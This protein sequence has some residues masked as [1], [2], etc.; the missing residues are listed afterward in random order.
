MNFFLQNALPRWPKRGILLPFF[1]LWLFSAPALAGL[2]QEIKLNCQNEKLEAVLK[3]IGKQSGLRILFRNADVELR[4]RV[5][6]QGTFALEK[7][8]KD[9]L[10]KH[11]LDYKIVG[12]QIVVFGRKKPAKTAT[13]PTENV[14]TQKTEVSG[15]VTDE[16]GEGLPGVNIIIKGTTTGTA[17][18]FEGRYTLVV[19]KSA[20]LQFSAVGFKAQEI[21][22][23]NQTRIDIML[24][25]NLAELEEV[26]V[27][28]YGEV[29]KS[30]LTGAVASLDTE[31]LESRP[32]TTVNSALQGAI[33]GLTIT[34]N[35]GQPGREGFSL[36][37]RDF[38]SVNGGS[39]PL[40]LIDGLPGS[41]DLLNPDD[42]Q[43]MSVLK[44]A[45][46][47]IYGSRAAG[48]VILITTKTGE[49]GKPTIE[50]KSNLTVK[51]PQGMYDQPTM[52]EYIE[53]HREAQSNAGEALW[54]PD[55]IYQKFL[56]GTGV[57]GVDEWFQD[58][59]KNNPR[60]YFYGETDWEDE[61]F[62]NSYI[63]NNSLS[64][65]GGGDKSKYRVSLGHIKDEGFFSIG[66][67]VME[68]YNL[69]LNYSYNVTDWLDVDAIVAFER[70]EID[71]T[72]ESPLQQY[73]RLNLMAPTH[74]ADGS[75][76][77]TW[78][79]FTNPLQLLDE[80]ARRYDNLTRLR[81]NFKATVKLAKGLKA[82]GQIGYNHSFDDYKIERPTFERYH[83]NGAVTAKVNN[84][85]RV[86]FSNYKGLYKNLTGFLN[87]TRTLGENHNFGLTAGYSYEE[88]SNNRVNAWRKDLI[89]NDLFAL[90]LGNSEEQF[91]SQSGSKW[92]IESYFGRF[93]YDFAG[94]YLIEANFRRDRSSKFHPDVR[95]GFFPGVSLGWAV[96]E[97]GFMQNVPVLDFLKLRASYGETGN[98]SIANAYSYIQTIDIG[99]QYPFG[100]GS[101]TARATLGGLP[102]VEGTW[103]TM[104]TRNFGVDFA[105]LDSRL[106]GSFDYYRK[107]NENMLINVVFPQ[108]LGASA[109]KVNEGTLEVKGWE[110]SLSWRDKIGGFQYFVTG[111]LS[112]SQN[113]LT[114]LGGKDT[115][116]AGLVGTREGYPINSYFGYD[117]MGPIKTEEELAEFKAMSGV[118]QNIQLGD[119]RYRD[120]D[121]NGRIDPY[122]DEDE[123]GDL[124]YLGNTSPRYNYS[125]N[126]GGSFRN[127]DIA[128]FF[129]GVGKKTTYLGGQFGAP[130]QGGAKWYKPNAMYH[131]TT[132]QPAEMD[133]NGNV[134]KEAREGEYPRLST[135][136]GIVGWNWR[137]SR[138]RALD[139]AY[140][141][142]KNVTVGYT[143][144]KHLT[145]RLR[146][147]R[148]RVFANGT[149]LLTFHNMK[150]GY[151]PEQPPGSALSYPFAKTYT[152]G[153]EVRF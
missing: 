153:L 51:T 85:N 49:K 28:G 139:G 92:G 103:E 90:P 91:N 102:S 7:T 38:S 68:R 142:L 96:S 61:L 100:S 5:S 138:L 115:Y 128:L 88:S 81:T 112:D 121:G 133:G 134:V 36:Q 24:A 59:G 50:F 25:P 99:K 106:K 108:T 151:D 15:T 66:N 46:A 104:L 98:Q 127:F 21:M 95:D 111:A 10:K 89:S 86:E 126:M 56:D 83:W 94:R 93:N 70:R 120:V 30:S 48:G 60:Y 31:V 107:E 129:Q 101:K 13:E 125:V 32:V 35:G 47:A 75:Q 2:D 22:V 82:V 8:L 78:G 14:Q 149:D 29:K 17:T 45:A 33:P 65:S 76:Y 55:D 147:N 87:Y 152:L 3:E 37:L 122:G 140:L 53:M 145:E 23:G 9:L 146:I 77:Y 84:P 44:D 105:L 62:N 39:S 113:E 18:D 58:K 67:N 135:N 11:S 69:K 144:P 20:V 110:L 131:N 132:Y 26:V 119:S 117:Y 124:I 52:M 73:Q 141:R 1:L 12:D 137:A 118:Q 43:S 148:L 80:G 19:D 71:E 41:L 97:E 4:E 136:K 79:G 42:I 34:R 6:L 57:D 114:H 40:V 130:Y 54:F 116:N 63:R 72:D 74:I 150:G 143:F 109:P 27:V 123:D 64:L 16:S